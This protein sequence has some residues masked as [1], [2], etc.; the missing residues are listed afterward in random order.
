MSEI[1]EILIY[2]LPGQLDK[3]INSTGYVRAVW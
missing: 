1:W 2:C 3:R